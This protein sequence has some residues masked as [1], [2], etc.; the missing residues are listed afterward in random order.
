MSVT[1]KIK[2]ELNDLIKE[3][4]CEIVSVALFPAGDE[5]TLQIMIE[6]S[7]YSSATIGDCEKVSR[8]VAVHLDVLNL[9][10]GK[11]NLEISSTGINRP[12][13]KK[14]DFVRFCNSYVVVKTYVLKNE[15]K[16]FKGLLKSATE[17]G[18]KLDLESQLPD[19]SC[20]IEFEYAEICGADRKS[21]V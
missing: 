8:T 13:V 12:L 17:Q 16:T 21:V 6:R 9:I 20:E 2:L 5:R 19:G 7:D 11:Y 10:H 4:E 14:E 1:E 18:I 3:Y 15:R